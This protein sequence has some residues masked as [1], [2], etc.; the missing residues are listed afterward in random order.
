MNA[1]LIR[2]RQI[3]G[4]MKLR[5]QRP[6]ELRWKDG[7]TELKADGREGFATLGLDGMEAGFVEQKKCK[8]YVFRD[9]IAKAPEIDTIFEL[10]GR[11]DRWKLKIISSGLSPHDLLW[12]FECVEEHS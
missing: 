1:L 8:F 11:E 2:N 12:I 10:G 9:L 3:T 4:E 5:E 6:C 7:P